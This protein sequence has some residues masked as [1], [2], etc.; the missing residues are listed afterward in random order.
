MIAALLLFE[1][2]SPTAEA[3]L[4]FFGVKRTSN[5]KGVTIP[6]QRRFVSYFATHLNRY[7]LASGG[8]PA[9]LPATPHPV[10][11]RLMMVRFHTIPSFDVGGGCDPYF[12]LKGPP[13][14]EATLYDYRV[15]LK[16]HGMKV[17]SCHDSSVQTIDLPVPG[18][19]LS[20]GAASFVAGSPC[21]VMQGCIVAGDFKLVFVDEDTLTGDDAMFHC[22]LNTAF[23][24]PHSKHVVLTKMECDK[25]N[26]DKRNKHFDPNFR[27][28]LF[29]AD[30]SDGS[31]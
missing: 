28:E 24:D 13:P 1:G 10:P 27:V 5:G 7:R 19:G 26:K 31:S 17:Q 21:D 29:F 3:A 15:A 23:I 9:S 11:L 6:S 12:L 22:W 4:H 20:G 14:T 2:H 30:L 8:L 25:A 16:K 18:T